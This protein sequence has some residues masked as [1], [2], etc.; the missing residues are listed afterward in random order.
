[1]THGGSTPARSGTVW[2]CAA[3][4]AFTHVFW[5]ALTPL[6]LPMQKDLELP[7]VSYCT[8]LVTVMMVAYFVP[9]YPV[10]VLADRV[11]RKRLLGV[12][13]LLNS[14][15]FVGLGLAPNFGL[16]LVCAI[17]AGLGG[18]FYHPAS[19]SLVAGLFPATTGRALGVVGI[20]ASVGFFAGPLYAGWRAEAAGWRAPIIELGVAGVLMAIVFFWLA[21]EPKRSGRR[22]KDTGVSDGLGGGIL[23]MVLLVGLFLSLRDFAGSAIGSGGALFLQQAHGFS[24]PATGFALSMIFLISAISN[25]LFGHLADRRLGLWLVIALLGASVVVASLPHLSPGWLVPAFMAYGFFFMGSFPM[26]E[27][28]V[29]TSVP[30]ELRGRVMGVFITVGGLIGNLGHWWAGYEVASLGPAADSASGYIGFFDINAIMIVG[31]LAA[32]PWLIRLGRLARARVGAVV[33][34][35]IDSRTTS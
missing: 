25:P 17:L 4:H 22:S 8:F 16:A 23:A 21:K 6:Y 1:M 31:A 9:S 18:S 2:L 33:S 24:L 20:G 3:L 27:M 10:G 14:L 26:T 28:A 11:S 7:N 35:R 30:D 34:P 13:L 19:A 5:V 32:L 15:A 29:V 12:G